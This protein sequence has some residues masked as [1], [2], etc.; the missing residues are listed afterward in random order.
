L[1]GALQL[2]ALIRQV[3]AGNLNGALLSVLRGCESGLSEFGDTRLEFILLALHSLDIALRQS[4]AHPSNSRAGAP[5]FD[6]AG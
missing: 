2:K 3:P 6:L 4:S 1:E 5:E